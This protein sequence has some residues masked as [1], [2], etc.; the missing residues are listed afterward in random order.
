M[1][2]RVPMESIA[3][4]YGEHDVKL[5]TGSTSLSLVFGHL[6]GDLTRLYHGVIWVH[7][8]IFED[9]RHPAKSLE[10]HARPSH[11]HSELFLDTLPVKARGIPF[12]NII[13]QGL[14]DCHR[15]LTITTHCK[16]QVQFLQVFWHSISFY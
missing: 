4:A 8:A 1:V 16:T 7:F 11:G 15:Y 10:V 5:L 13:V 2:T 12:R 14:W 9:T 3:K 6:C